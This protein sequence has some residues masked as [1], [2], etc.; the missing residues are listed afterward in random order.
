MT[1]M[2]ACPS[3]LPIG[4][5]DRARRERSQSPLDLLGAAM[6]FLCL[7]IKHPQKCRFAKQYE[8]VRTSK[9]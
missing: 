2:M 6:R 3:L 7:P 8:A 4:R 1:E 5:I 9:G